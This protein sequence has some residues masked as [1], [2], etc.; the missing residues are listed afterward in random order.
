ML[1]LETAT[2]ALSVAL[3]EEGRPRL[4]LWLDAGRRHA[5]LLTPLV[6][7]AL[8]RL[9]A[10]PADLGAVAVGLGPGSFTGLRIGAVTGRALASTLG[11]PAL[12]VPTLAAMARA[13]G[14][15]LVVPLLDAR[16]GRLYTALYRVA[17][18]G[19]GEVSPLVDPLAE[20]AVS[21]WRR[22]AEE[23]PPGPLFLT[24]PGLRRY[25]EEARTALG[26]RALLVPPSRW[27]PRASEVGALAW[28]RLQAGE[29][30][31]PEALEPLYFGRQAVPWKER[32]RGDAAHR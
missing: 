10:R 27:L 24:G 16:G 4:E 22:L 25:A 18:D 29:A 8:E 11:I 26:G 31:G 5:A 21:W 23:A 17:A 30:G 3:L 32:E 2:E 19:T 6:D 28:E 14:P 1:A 13:A 7:A 9:G 20:S 15:G 12:G